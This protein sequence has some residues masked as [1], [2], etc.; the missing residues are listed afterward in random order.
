MGE[1]ENLMTRRNRTWVLFLLAVGFLFAAFVLSTA[2]AS[3]GNSVKV[4][5]LIAFT[6]Q[7][8]PAEEALVRGAGGEIK[9]TYTIVPAIAADIPEGAIQ[10]LEQNLRIARIDL[11]LE[12][13]I[14][15]DYASELE[16]TW[17]VAHIGGG[18]AHEERFL[19]AGVRVA[20]LDTG[21]RTTP[22]THS[23]LS[24]DHLCSDNVNYHDG[25]GHGTHVAGTVAALRNGMGVVGVAPE[26]TLCIFKV[27]SDEGGGSYSEVIR[28]LELIFE[29]N[30]NNP[31][32]PIRITNN[33][34]GSSGDP[35]PT[36]KAAFD[37]TS[38][39]G[40]L[41]VA[42]AG[43]S[44]NQGGG[45][46][47]C[48]YPARWVSLIATA[49]TQKNDT[50]ASFSSTCAELEL[51]APGV[52]INST[53]HDGGYREASGTSMASPHAAG[54]AALTWAANTTLTNVQV[55][56]ILQE[57][58]KPIGAKNQYGY[59][60]VQAL[61]AAQDA[62]ASAP[63]EI[64]NLSG[65]VTDG[66]NPIAGAEVVLG[67]T[68]FKAFTD[69]L[70]KYLIEDIPVGSYQAT[71]SAEDYQSKSHTV[72]ILDGINITLDFVLEQIQTGTLAGTVTDAVSDDPIEGAKVVLDGTDLE[73]TTDIKGEYSISGIPVGNF[74]ATAS[75]DWYQT[76]SE[77]VSITKDSI[78]TQDFSLQPESSHQLLRVQISSGQDDVNQSC[79]FKVNANEIYFGWDG[80]CNPNQLY[81][82][83]FLFRNVTIPQGAT[84]T[85]A[86]IEF[87]VD[88][89]YNNQVVVNLCGQAGD[90]FEG[91]NSRCDSSPV[92]RWDI[93]TNWSSRMKFNSPDI[94]SV[95]QPIISREDWSQGNLI[96]TGD[97]QSAE[98]K[99]VNH[100]RVFA[101]ERDPQSAAVLVV[102]YTQ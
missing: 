63:S 84:I 87:V 22:D 7:P 70:G 69:N 65:T 68:S 37:R 26:A 77:D 72:T 48:I 45:G 97:S 83:G 46:S 51:S 36:V 53:S 34:Y 11:D 5:V 99:R 6:D 14:A 58:V 43:N 12:I 55:R 27:L 28:A 78:K 71:V 17:G 64:G 56:A 39:A 91:W 3:T 20:I 47:N 82:A 44:G 94:T 67:G 61:A 8:G 57:T 98:R 66:E 42:A 4:P 49:A 38:E 75:A 2:Q 21:I 74:T 41:H 96:I 29:Y 25:H 19:G 15:E 60:L 23:D 24:H 52:G 32:D 54:T 31:Y 35:G 50:R 9:Y 102:E 1:G 62:A 93:N 89:P 10:G 90:S 100:R 92:V 80:S 59:G 40:V 18:A 30:D 85:S 13:H 16:N 81:S 73:G 86:Y 79:N 101:Y 95:I 88:G 33:S 76:Q